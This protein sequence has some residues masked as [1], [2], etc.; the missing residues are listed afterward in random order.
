M[1]YREFGRAGVKVSAIGMGTY[2]GSSSIVTA[3]L[4]GYNIG[5][6][7]KIAALRKGIDL[8]INLIDTA[9]VYQTEPLI[10]DAI[11]EYRRDDLF[12]ATKVLFLHLRYNQLLKAAERS[13]RMLQTSYIDLYQIHQPCPWV[14]IRETMRAMEKLVEEGKVKYIGVSNFSLARF[15]DAENTLS[16]CELVSNQVE[17]NL[18]VRRIETD[19]LP[20]CEKNKIAVIAYRPIAHGALAQPSGDL[21]H[22]VH[23]ISEKYGGKTPVQIALNWLLTRSKVVFPIPRASRPAR[24]VENVRAVEW[25]IEATDMARLEASVR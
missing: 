15:K 7:D 21:S 11:K 18:K 9:E 2:Y 8:G 5:R 20:Y 1:E 13:L 6:K 25:T 12:I 4:F 24:V 16:K 22:V 23:D 17:Y 19:L 14:P 10:A 3:R